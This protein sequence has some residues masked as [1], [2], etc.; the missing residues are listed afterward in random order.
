MVLIYKFDKIYLF[1]CKRA[2]KVSCQII[3]VNIINIQQVGI[4][5]RQQVVAVGLAM[6]PVVVVV[7]M[8]IVVEMVVPI[9]AATVTAAFAAV[10]PILISTGPSILHLIL[11]W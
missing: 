10:A 4:H 5:G 9:T 11:Q 8:M 3:R 1:T 2:V 7:V 6:V